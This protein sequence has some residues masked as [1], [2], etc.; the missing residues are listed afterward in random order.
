MNMEARMF[1]E[2]LFNVR[3]LVGR[4]VVADQM[5]RL[6]LRGLPIDL[7]QE[8]EP[9]D[10]PMTLLATRDDGTVKRI[11]R[12]EQS[13]GSVALVIVRHGAGLARL[14]RQAGL[15]AIR[16]LQNSLCAMGSS[17]QRRA[18]ESRKSLR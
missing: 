7:T 4:L 1:G 13:R 14:H 12:R 18:K 3:M 17:P 10:M 16:H 9:L 15:G 6:V 8:R 2:P 11:H 5:Q